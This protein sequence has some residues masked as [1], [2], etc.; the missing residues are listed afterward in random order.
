MDIIKRIILFVISH[1]ALNVLLV[2]EQALYLALNPSTPPNFSSFK[3][4]VLKR[5]THEIE[6]LAQI[7][8]D[9]FNRPHND[10]L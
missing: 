4:N 7:V 9:L 2:F 3:G 8:P 1:F 10:L 5:I 6:N